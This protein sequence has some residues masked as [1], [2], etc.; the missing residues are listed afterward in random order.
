VSLP[1][2]I[3]AL[4]P[5]SLSGE[6]DLGRLRSAL[7]VAV[8]AGLRGVLLREPR[9]SD[10]DLLQLIE[11]ARELLPEPGDWLALHDRVHLAE[12]VDA[13]HLGFR[14]LPLE[15]ARACCRPSVSV[16]LSTHAGDAPETWQG[17][18]YRFLGPV[19]ATPSKEGWVEPLGVEAF[20][21]SARLGAHPVWAIGGIEPAHAP[22]L[23]AAGASGVAVL[24]GILQSP[25][26]AGA[27]RAYT[28]AW[29]SE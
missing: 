17:A 13:V 7:R 3:V 20:A 16:G 1:P 12:Q 6:R 5:G 28:E 4:S 25:D 23:R 9:L 14:S 26:P 27:V 22:A 8:G 29:G 19:F 18:D 10:R 15:Q 24:R 2:P 11:H 21:S